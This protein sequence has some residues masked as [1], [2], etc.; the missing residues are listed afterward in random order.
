[1]KTVS[2]L[3]VEQVGQIMNNKLDNHSESILVIGGGRMGGAI[4]NG[5]IKMG[6]KPQ[7]IS[8]IDPNE[9]ALVPFK[10]QGI[11][12]FTNI[13]AMPA[14]QS[15][16][17]ILV[18]LKPQV[19]DVV[20]PLYQPLLTQETL[21]ISIAAGVTHS[22]IEQLLFNGQPVIRVMPNTP[23]LINSG[24]MVGCSNNCV[25]SSQKTFCE[26]LFSNLGS[27]DWVDDEHAMHAVTA[28]SGSGPAYLFH[29]VECMFQ[30]AKDAGLTNDL[31]LI[32]TK[33]TVV[34]AAKLVEQDDRDVSKLR[35]EVTSPN[36]T[37]AAA[38]GVLMQDG[39]LERLLSDAIGSAAKRSVELSLNDN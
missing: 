1:M 21:V 29:F 35:E 23:A 7:T 38:L 37:T 19:F 30:A 15:Y 28:V 27:F 26:S 25:S 39:A 14:N 18:A 32:L 9:A 6:I 33:N 11:N 2:L 20:L 31:A 24:V 3:N 8:I 22:T 5:W 16:S 4:V 13:D 34:G 36:G 12:T 10:S 17:C